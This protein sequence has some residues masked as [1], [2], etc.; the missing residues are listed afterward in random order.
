MMARAIR[1]KIKGKKNGISTIIGG[2]IIGAIILI[3]FVGYFSFEFSSRTLIDQAAN[4]RNSLDRATE[5]QNIVVKALLDSSGNLEVNISNNRG[6]SS[7]NVV[8]VFVGNVYPYSIITSYTG[9]QIG[10][11]SPGFYVYDTSV[12]YTTGNP[13]WAKIVT[14]LDANALTVYPPPVTSPN[15][16]GGGGTGLNTTEGNIGDLKLN[17]QTFSWYRVSACTKAN[18]SDSGYCLTPSQGAGNGAFTIYQKDTTLPLAFSA[19]VVDVNPQH[20]SITL[21]SFTSFIQFQSCGSSIC[22]YKWFILS[23]ASGGQILNTFAPMTLKYGEPVTLVFGNAASAPCTTSCSP[24]ASFQPVT[25]APQFGIASNLIF[26]HGWKNISLSQPANFGQN[27]PFVATVYF[28]PTITLSPTSGPVGTVVTVNGS[29]FSPSS[30]ITIRYNQT[31][32][33]TVVSSTA[34]TFTTTFTVPPSRDVNT[35][36]ATD[37]MGNFASALFNVPDINITS[38]PPLLTVEN[39]ASRTST[40]TVTSLYGFTGTVALSASISPSTGLTASFNPTTV[41]LGTTA[42]STLTFSASVPGNYTV[43]VIGVGTYSGTTSTITRSTTLI[44]AVPTLTISPTSGYPNVTQITLSGADYLASTIYSYCLSTSST[45]ISC[46]TGTTHTFTSNSSGYIPSGTT[47]A[48]PSSATAGK[49]YVLVY[50]TTTIDAYATFQVQDF[51]MT[52]NPATRAIS[53]GSNSYSIIN[54]TSLNGFAGTVTLTTSVSPSTGLSVSLK[55]TS[56]VLGTSGTSNMTFSSTAP[57]TYTITV[58]G[59]SNGVTHSVIVTVTVGLA[60]TSTSVSCVPS[61]IEVGKSTTSTC[62]ATV[63]GGYFPTGTI[64]FTTTGTGSVT[65][66]AATC[67]LSGGNCSVVFSSSSAGSVTVTGTYAGNSNNQGSSGIFS[68]TVAGALTA[69]T[70]SVSPTVRD[71]GQSATLSTTTSFSGGVSPYTCQW[72]VK[73]P[74]ATGYSNLGASF[75]CSA[76]NLPTVPTGSLSSTGTWSF[77]LQVTDSLQTPVTVASNVVIVTVNPTLSAVSVSP[78][79]S[80]IDSGQSSTITVSWSGGT[81]SY[82]VSLYSGTSSSSCALDSTLVY[83]ATGVSGTTTTFTVSPSSTTY[84]CATVT[85]NPSTT[86]SSTTPSQLTVNPALVAPVIA[87]NA[88]AL[89]QGQTAALTSTA[90]T[91]GTSPYAY[92]WYAMAPGS[93]IFSLISGANSPDYNFTTSVSTA[94]GNWTF[95]L[96]VTDSAGEIVTSNN[97]TITVS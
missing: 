60:P 89:T 35:V 57:G 27:M 47:L 37:S 86:A 41:T 28:T 56:I 31:V 94:T 71:S 21:D 65:P 92:Q 75:A 88:T 76:G 54:V 39:G 63:N 9:L 93:S 22:A 10:I 62:T 2:V 95:E 25:Y 73:A 4:Q 44:V 61:S 32:V 17:F 50:Q 90:I 29:Y 11:N 79:P 24:A 45:S 69:P 68:L 81:P 20:F 43:K 83:T 40:I 52:A 91:T 70:I 7:I 33:A 19:S 8:A 78:S 53:V 84:Y 46:L 12:K 48:V 85:D 5:Q 80:T 66:S 51:S 42:I 49:D 87:T 1:A 16:P 36:N 23:N 58:R 6:S 34:G 64:S 26:G 77:E 59:T 72:L 3:V 97:V 74:S 67:T 14:S 96:V 18:P 38:N 13:L 82:T 55:T 15:N 30:T